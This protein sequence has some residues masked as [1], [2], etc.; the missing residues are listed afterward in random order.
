M[1]V[2]FRSADDSG[3]GRLDAADGHLSMQ[4]AN[5]RQLPRARTPARQLL[6][7]TEAAIDPVIVRHATIGAMH[8]TTRPN[9]AFDPDETRTDRHLGVRAFVQSFVM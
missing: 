4:S 8:R 3:A 6:P 7:A 2:R 1:V 9:D 5:G